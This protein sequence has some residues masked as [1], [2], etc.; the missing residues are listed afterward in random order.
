MTDNTSGSTSG[1]QKSDPGT[2]LE[3]DP[4]Q[5]GQKEGTKSGE[6]EQAQTGSENRVQDETED[7]DLK[8]SGGIFETEDPLEIIPPAATEQRRTSTMPRKHNK[9]EFNPWGELDK[10]SKKNVSRRDLI[11]GLFRFL[12][13]KDEK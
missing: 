12:P 6:E 7:G 5:V 10:A 8:K 4:M 3:A 13:R 2:T 1:I 11:T 9:K